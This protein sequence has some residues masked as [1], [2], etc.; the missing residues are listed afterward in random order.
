MT[1]NDYDLQNEHD[2]AVSWA[3]AALAIPDAVIL[4]TETTGLDFDS[5]V[6]QIAVLAI[7]GEVLLDTYV[8]PKQPIPA[9]A[10][11]IH[12]ITDD[13]VAQAPTM[14]E[15]YPRLLEILTDRTVYIYNSDFDVRLIGQSIGKAMALENNIYIR[16]VMAPYSVYWGE[17]SEY[18]QA[19]KWQRLPGGDHSALGDCRA[20]LQLLKEMANE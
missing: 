4:D 20:V 15:L 16:D 14:V 18:H 3:Q 2:Q 13:M 6:V 1:Y 19:Y 11:R 7:T 12:H 17:W 8:R 5:E 10:T 9:S